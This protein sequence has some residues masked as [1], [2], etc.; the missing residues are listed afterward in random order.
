M[1]RAAARALAEAHPQPVVERLGEIANTQSV[2]RRVQAIEALGETREPLAVPV[3]MPLLEDDVVV[4]VVATRAALVVITQQDF[5]RDTE[6]WLAWWDEN[7]GRHRLEW[8][9]DSLMHEQRALRGSASEEL[10][11]ITKEYFAYYDDLPK[12]E[13]ERAQA[14]YRDWWDNIGRV[15]F[16]R[17][18]TRGA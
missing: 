4:V 10:R 8:L 3:L 7:R 5:G 16:S 6:K 15:R 18:S 17:A 12:R 2:V 11:T 1:A 14:R 13:R 9:I